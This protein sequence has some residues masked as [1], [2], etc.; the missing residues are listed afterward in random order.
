MVISI[1]KFLVSESSDDELG[2]EDVMHIHSESEVRA[3]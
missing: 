2:M 1:S 3:T